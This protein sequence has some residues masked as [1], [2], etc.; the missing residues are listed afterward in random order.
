MLPV[1]FAPGDLSEKSRR[2]RCH[3]ESTIFAGVGV[4][5]VDTTYL[6]VGLFNVA[7]VVV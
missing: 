7:V 4:E 5:E 3:T 1:F 2:V 6:C